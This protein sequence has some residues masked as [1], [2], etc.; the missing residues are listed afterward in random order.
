MSDSQ[1]PAPPMG[2]LPPE[3]QGM[4][5]NNVGDTVPKGVVTPTGFFTG[6]EIA[7]PEY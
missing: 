3:A 5:N 2:G 1:H 6:F 7:N 4:V